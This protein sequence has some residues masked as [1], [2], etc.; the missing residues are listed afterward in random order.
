MN[1]TLMNAAIYISDFDASFEI[2]KLFM[3]KHH[4]SEKVRSSVAATYR[5]N[6]DMKSIASMYLYP[7]N[8]SVLAI[9]SSIAGNFR[10]KSAHL[11]ML[12]DYLNEHPE[13]VEN[14]QYLRW[15]HHKTDQTAIGLTHIARSLNN[16]VVIR[17]FSDD[18]LS[19]YK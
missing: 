9:R 15:F 3:F 1:T 13:Y 8:L 12:S 4:R 6:G 11:K 2:D 7:C 10:S 14:Y 16:D 19:N 17:P 18:D 5:I